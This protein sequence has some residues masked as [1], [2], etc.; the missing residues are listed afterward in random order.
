MDDTPG[1]F[2]DPTKETFAQFRALERP[3]PVHMLNLVRFREH[4]AYEDGTVATK[5]CRIYCAS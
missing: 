3:G 2:V 1:N 5:A 4:A